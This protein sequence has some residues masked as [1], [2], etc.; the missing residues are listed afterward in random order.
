MSEA[1]SGHFDGVEHVLPPEPR[2]EQDG[3]NGIDEEA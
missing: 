3:G 1:L 2:H